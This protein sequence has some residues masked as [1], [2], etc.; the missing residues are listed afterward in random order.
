MSAK[1]SENKEALTDVVDVVVFRKHWITVVL[2]IQ[3]DIDDLE[4]T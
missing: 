3:S 1:S 2:G 4:K